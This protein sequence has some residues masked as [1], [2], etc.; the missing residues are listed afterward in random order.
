[1]P[2]GV[3]GLRD[4]DLDKNVTRQA[5]MISQDNAGGA[6]SIDHES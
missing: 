4:G 6:N 1:M 2:D 3:E 5:R